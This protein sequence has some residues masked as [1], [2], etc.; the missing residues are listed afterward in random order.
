MSGETHT[1]KKEKEIQDTC[2]S[3]SCKHAAHRGAV[4]R[5][6]ADDVGRFC[7]AGGNKCVCVCVGGGQCGYLNKTALVHAAGVKR[8]DALDAGSRGTI[9]NFRLQPGLIFA[10]SPHPH[11]FS[12][13]VG[14]GREGGR[15]P[16]VM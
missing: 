3:V 7:F 15:C 8:G 10:V 13:G 5:R 4:Q 2:V 1:G 14:G 9:A 12:K 6:G 16:C 11:S